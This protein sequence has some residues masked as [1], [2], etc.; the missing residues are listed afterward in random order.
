MGW[1]VEG[2]DDDDLVFLFKSTFL[3]FLQG[4]LNMIDLLQ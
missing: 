4:N 2:N 1:M 3:Y